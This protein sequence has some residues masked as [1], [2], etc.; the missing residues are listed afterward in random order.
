MR[1]VNWL[2]ALKGLLSTPRRTRRPVWRQ[3]RRLRPSSRSVAACTQPLE[4]RLVLSASPVA[5]ISAPP[6]VDEGSN[7]TVSAAGSYD[8]DW[9]GMLEYT[10]DFN[11]D[12][13]FGDGWGEQATFDPSMWASSIPDGAPITIRVQVNDWTDPPTIASTTITV[14]NVAPTLSQISFPTTADPQS[15][16]MLNATLFDPGMSEQLQYSLSRGDG[17]PVETGQGLTNGNISWSWAYALPGDYTV[18]LTVWD[19]DGGVASLTRTI[20]INEPTFGQPTLSATSINEGSMT[21]LT[22]TASQDIASWTIHWGD[23]VTETASG[24]GPSLSISH[25][26]ADDEAGPTNSAS[27]GTDDKYQIQIIAHTAAGNWSVTKKDSQGNAVPLEVTVNN[28]VPIVTSSP[29]ISGGDVIEEVTLPT[30]TFSAE[31]GVSPS[32]DSLSWKIGWGDGTFTS[33][34]GSSSQS[35]VKAEYYEEPGAYMV[36]LWVWDEDMR[37]E[38]AAPVELALNVLAKL[39][40]ADKTFEVKEDEAVNHLVG[41]IASTPPATSYVIDAGND[42]GKFTLDA[43]TG[44]IK[45]AQKLDYEMRTIYLLRVKATLGGQ[46]VTA[47]VTVNVKDVDEPPVLTDHK[48]RQSTEGDSIGWQMQARDP[49]TGLTDGQLDWTITGLPAGLTAS[50]SGMV[51]GRI[52]YTE[53]GVKTV[54][55][56]VRDAAGNET[57]DTFAWTIDDS[58]IDKL[59]GQEVAGTSS[60]PNSVQVSG[61]STDILWVSGSNWGSV[62]NDVILDYTSTSAKRPLRPDVH[63]QVTGLTAGSLTGTF[64]TTPVVPVD[65]ST[66]SGAS[67]T[68]SAGI[69]A[70][71]DGTLTTGEITHR[72]MIY[73]LELDDAAAGWTVYSQRTVAPTWDT[74]HDTLETSAFAVKVNEIFDTASGFEFSLGYLGS[75]RSTSSLIK[76]EVLDDGYTYNSTLA[77]GSGEKFT[78]TFT[79]SGGKSVFIRFYADANNDGTRNFGEAYSD[80]PTFRVLD[81]KPYSFNTAVSSAIQAFHVSGVPDL[82]L[83]QDQVH[84]NFNKAAA[85]LMRK[86]GAG[87]YRAAVEFQMTSVTL[88]AEPSLLTPAELIEVQ[89]LSYNM[90]FVNDLGG[91]APLNSTNLHLGLTIEGDPGSMVIDWRE[92]SN[93][94]VLPVTIAHETGHGIRVDKVFPNAVGIPEGHY[95]PETHVQY[96]PPYVM[97]RGA[98]AGNTWLTLGDANVFSN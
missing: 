36:K 16:V 25:T 38:D 54:T 4:A 82:T 59:I 57:T 8:P 44:E 75:A 48:N 42:D 65:K 67:L 84:S 72:F 52:H 97:Y 28:V 86:D 61:M 2:G 73:L 37:E 81:P 19:K 74:A 62:W 9:S 66:M 7:V 33:G 49:E 58:A 34:S 45:L 70:N 26:Y 83:I 27:A 53:Q 64:D 60:L 96:A 40:M 20:H 50:A 6:T 24:G 71:L 35:A 51:T 43:A 1:M 30:V 63:W 68:V 98:R 90:V 31:D 15:T 5:V 85:L 77:S 14:T 3:G 56:K 91:L 47:D 13:Y 32:M 92:A 29:M 23:G 41:T 79:G 78:H 89:N 55:V 46:E 11:N 39:R 17:S 69:D 18:S 76:Y 12:G 21:N 22:V 10:W 88:I 87:D 95:N 93:K 94:S 80:S